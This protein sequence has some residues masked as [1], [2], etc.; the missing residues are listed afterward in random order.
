[1][2]NDD[3]KYRIGGDT[4]GFDAAMKSIDRRANETA[5]AVEGA[6]GRAGGVMR[7]FG[8]GLLAGGAAT[9]GGALTIGALTKMIA[10]TV[11]EINDLSAAAKTAGVEF[12]AFQELEYAA[13]RNLVGVG[14]LT[15]GLKEMQLRLDEVLKTG[16]GAAAEALGAL[17]FRADELAEK[18]KQP[19]KLFEDI[20]ERMKAFDKASQIR[21]ADEIFGGTAGEQF[22]RL[23]DD[24]AAKI[25]DLRQ[26]ARDL[27]VIVDVEL[28]RSIA[29]ATREWDMMSSVIDTK[30]KR[31]AIAVLNVL[32][33]IVDTFR[34]MDNWSLTNLDDELARITNRRKE[35]AREIEAI[36]R[37]QQ[38]NFS[39][40]AAV[41]NM[42][43]Q[44]TIV[45]LEEEL[46]K[47]T[48]IEEKVKSIKSERTAPDD[49]GVTYT[50]TM[51]VDDSKSRGAS[52]RAMREQRDAA[53]ELIASLEEEIFM[54]GMADVDRA[55]EMNLRRAGAQA[56]DEQRRKIEEKTRA[57]YAEEA[58]LEDVRR[59]MEAMEGVGYFMGDIIMD[60][61]DGITTKSFDAKKAL[62][63]LLQ[64]FARGALMGQGVFGKLFGGGGLPSLFGNL[65]GGFR[66]SGG[67]V[68]AG[69]AYMVGEEGPEPFIPK[70]DGMIL[71]HGAAVGGNTINVGGPT[72]NM[73]LSGAQRGVGQEVQQVLDKVLADF[74][75]QVVRSLREIKIKGIQV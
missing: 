11:K 50:P 5:R 48:E 15:D 61:L 47:L 20:I 12:E 39:G 14:A 72:I 1:M 46:A 45:A 59:Q 58:A 31:T 21:L 3:L 35:I 27:G 32:L 55:V 23:L 66:A 18:L 17:G 29:D 4:S 34:E 75:P 24:S 63:G 43:S 28:Q 70:T 37:D 65:F 56:T 54:L 25:S 38:T 57:L 68:K 6:F 41:E 60:A 51:F 33:D 64:E 49:A 69:R 30:V 13:K 62:A 22:V 16:K 40:A 67:P 19:D 44:G 42:I 74:T 26:E 73:D 52:A 7:T 53:A 8:K 2:S 9:L 71:P 10:D 36:Q